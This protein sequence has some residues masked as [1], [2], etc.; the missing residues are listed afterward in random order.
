LIRIFLENSGNWRR[1]RKGDKECVR[2]LPKDSVV[3]NNS[4]TLMNKPWPS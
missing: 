3:E 2:N 4:K 1:E